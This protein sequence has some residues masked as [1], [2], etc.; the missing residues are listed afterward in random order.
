MAFFLYAIKGL[1]LKEF[2]ALVIAGLLFIPLL[3][4]FHVLQ[5]GLDQKGFLE[6]LKMIYG[7]IP[8]LGWLL[9]V[10]GRKSD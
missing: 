8:G 6:I 1:E 5:S 3:G 9:K 10:F 7:K 4:A 2:G